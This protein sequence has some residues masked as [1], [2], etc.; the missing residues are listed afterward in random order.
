VTYFDIEQATMLRRGSIIYYYKTKQELFDAVVEAMLLDKSTIL[1]VPIPDGDV[2]KNFIADFVLNCKRLQKTMAARG[3]KNV[4]LA[5]YIIGS[6]ALCHFAD[7][8]KRLRQMRKVEL[9]IWT[10]VVNKAVMNGEISDAVNTDTLARLFMNSYYGHGASAVRRQVS[11]DI[12][13]LHKELTT[14]YNL[15]KSNK[16]LSLHS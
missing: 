6:N 14:L 5:Y 2:L 1:N 15:V 11:G 12:D 16:Q 8:D 7:F 13:L 10:Q 4:F 9:D 3:I